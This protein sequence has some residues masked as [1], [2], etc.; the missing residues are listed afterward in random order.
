MVG[1][2]GPK[3]VSVEKVGEEGEPAQVQLLSKLHMDFSSLRVS[4]PE[5]HES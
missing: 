3:G 1:V 4:L 2:W 5:P